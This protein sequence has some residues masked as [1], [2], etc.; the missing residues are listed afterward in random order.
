MHNMIDFDEALERTKGE[1]RALLIGNGFSAEYFNYRNLLDN[2]GLAVGSPVR[3]IFNILG[4]VDFEAV[5]RALEGA[6]VVE[7]GYRNYAHAS[8][9]MLHAQMVREALVKA[10]NATHPIH[11]QD[12]GFQYTSSANF[13]ANFCTVFSLNYD[14]LLY[15]VNL[16]KCRLA[17]GFGLGESEGYFRGPFIEGAYCNLYNLHGGLHLFETD[18]GGI[19]KALDT[20][21]GVIATISDT[22]I[23]KRRLPLY[24]A[25]GTSSQ[26]MRK[27]NS[28]AYL[29]YCYDTLRWNSCSIFVYGHSA[30]END[31][32]IYRAI[33]GSKA[34]H[35]YFGVYKPN[36]EKINIFDGL[37]SKYQKTVGSHLEYTFFDS[38]TAKVWNA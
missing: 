5:I 1:E 8:E 27:I 10:V 18:D 24:V 23:N 11:R 4:T 6:V 22:I 35:L 28:V 32:H 31:A 26:K 12:L 29:R 36:P 7:Q 9:I 2:S 15:W 17:D 30:D 16:E 33:F 21:M 19:I 20:G 25:E 38:E 14:L 34:K 13:L 3:E 37:L